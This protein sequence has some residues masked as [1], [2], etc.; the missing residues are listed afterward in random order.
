M[1]SDQFKNV[2]LG[3]DHGGFELKEEVKKFLDEQ[4]FKV[5]DINPEYKNPI[6][7]VRSA[8]KVC[9]TVLK[10]ENTLG[11]LFCGTGI[12]ISIAANRIKNIRAAL[13]YDDFSAEYARRHNN[14]NVLV[15]GGRTMK[16]E[17]VK[18]RIKVFFDNQFEGG[19][20]AKRNKKIETN[21]K[22]E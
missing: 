10:E 12:G 17:D 8:H 21:I 14:A 4:N 1:L 6:D 2:V 18:E 9:E 16:I 22:G 20:Y 15:F 7:F 11:F 3:C 5:N 13:L 19:K